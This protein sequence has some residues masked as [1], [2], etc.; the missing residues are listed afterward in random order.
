[1]LDGHLLVDAHVHVPRLTMLAPAWIDWTRRFGRPGILEE[2]WAP[3]GAPDPTALDR[4]FAEEGVDV[5]LL[6]CE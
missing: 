5:A 1:M 3:D 4:L 6:F 2:V